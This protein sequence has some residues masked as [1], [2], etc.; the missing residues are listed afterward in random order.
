MRTLTKSRFK[1]GLEC[2]NK[3]FYTMKDKE[4]ANQKNDDPFLAALAQGGF[5]VE[6]LARMH[7]PDGHLVENGDYVSLWKQTEELL[8]QQNVVIYEAAFLFEDL[9]IRTDILV[10]KG[11]SI[12]LIEVKAKS[13]RPTDSNTFV[14][15]SGK[16]ISSWRPY[17]FDVAF[18]KYV[19]QKCF[20]D[21]NIKANLMLANKNAVATVDGLNQMFRISKKADNRTNIIKTVSSLSETGNIV[22]GVVNIDDI[23][24][25]IHSGKEKYLPNMGFEESVTYLNDLFQENK[26]ANWPVQYSA[27]KD[28]EFKASQED[29]QK[30]LKSGYKECF[31]KQLNWTKK[32]FE[33]PSIFEIWNFRK[34]NALFNEGKY[35]MKDLSDDDLQVEEASG[36]LTH[37][38]R[39]RLQIDY[40][41]SGD[42]SLYVDKDA[43]KEEMQLWKFPLHF[44]DFET[45]AV[46]LPFNKG[47]RPYEQIAFQFSHHTL[48]QDGRIEHSSQ[49]INANAGEFPNFEFIRALRKTLNNDDGT[50]FR[51]ATHENSIVNAIYDQ[52]CESTESDKDE[53]LEFIR[54]ISKSKTDRVE[55][56]HGERS[57]VDLCEVIKSYYYN[58]LTNGSNSIKMVLPAVLNSSVYLKEKYAQ[59]ISKIKVS[60]LNFP[61]T[62]IWLEVK[63]GKITNPYKMLPPLFDGWSEE[64]IE[65]TLSELDGVANGG[66]ALTAYGKL[67][68]TN[69][70]KAERNELTKALL[71]YC[72]LDTLAMVMIYEHL[73][74][75]V[76]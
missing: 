33:T 16:I 72:E 70:T 19:M 17:L 69:M 76:E 60:S 27:C 9:F 25:D 68:Y 65:S 49:H 32:D 1:L 38:A 51:Y 48:H 75:V 22:L 50:I 55:E 13:F 3:L 7:Y 42:D 12:E 26:Y 46:A 73:R 10:K 30:R 44:I 62:H 29:E 57:M 24:N 45:S 52:L 61:S 59:A 5:Q 6:E 53:L 8:Q 2:P 21:W 37:S 35:F 18:Q 41:I 34:G 20:P 4:Y 40:A 63:N 64:E 15:K 43:L 56:W 23:V 67:Q 28:C 66:A 14:G 36:F 54:G 11:N 58:P 74:E 47:R 39:Q 71:K 31:T